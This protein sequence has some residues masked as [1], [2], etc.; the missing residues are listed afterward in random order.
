M[1][2]ERFHSADEE[3]DAGKHIKAA[4][5]E[6]LLG[7]CVCGKI[8]FSRH[9]IALQ[10]LSRKSFYVCA[11]CSG[12]LSCSRCL[13]ALSPEAA[14]VV[15]EGQHHS[16]EILC[17]SCSESVIAGSGMFFQKIRMRFK[18]AFSHMFNRL[19]RSDIWPRRRRS[20]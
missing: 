6:K 18:A 2:E 19:F 8:Y 1:D 13:S 20:G 12:A 14:L 10:S 5:Y 3:K 7:C 15:E 11:E 16:L 4:F 9:P 17:N